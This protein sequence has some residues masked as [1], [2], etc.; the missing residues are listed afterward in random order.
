MIAFDGK[1][2]ARLRRR[3]RARVKANPALRKERN[4]VR[5]Q[6]SLV[7]LFGT[8][9]CFFWFVGFIALSTLFGQKAPKL[10]GDCFAIWGTAI[11]LVRAQLIVWYMYNPSIVWAAYILPLSDDAIFADARRVVLRAS[12]WSAGEGFV[13]G[14]ALALIYNADLIGW[15]AVP[16][17]AAAVWAGTLVL[18]AGLAA[19]RPSLPFQVGSFGI[20][21]ASMIALFGKDNQ[22]LFVAY[23]APMLDLLRMVLPH[24]WLATLSEQAVVRGE[25]GALLALAGIAAASALALPRLTAKLR[26]EFSPQKIFGYEEPQAAGQAPASAETAEAPQVEAEG[27]AASQSEEPVDLGTIRT[28]LQRELE[29]PAGLALFNLGYAERWITRALGERMRI[30]VDFMRPRGLPVAKR[31]GLGLAVFALARMMQGAAH[32]SDALL[33]GLVGILTLALCLFP[34]FGGGWAGF[35]LVALDRLQTGMYAFTPLGFWEIALTVLA[36]NLMRILIVG[37]LFVLAAVA[38]FPGHASTLATCDSALRGLLLILSAQPF[39][40]AL[41]F[42]GFT[43]DAPW[44]WWVTALKLLLILGGLLIGLVLA[45]ACFM[46]QTALVRYGMVALAAIL[47]LLAMGFYGWLWSR[48]YFDLAGRATAQT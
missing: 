23:V 28:G 22:P 21:I 41:R 12:L 11:V 32:P 24:G 16:L 42:P 35:Q 44:R 47:S 9:T 5:R 6:R 36:V 40:I 4:R 48:T 15:L 37:P 7:S 29:Q 34:L 3:V 46:A 17:V 30:V 2:V 38:F 1:I 43:N 8:L 33:I 13:Y 26:A 18:A 14:C 19:F 25:W 20:G 45:I 10:A 27:A 39:M 31:V